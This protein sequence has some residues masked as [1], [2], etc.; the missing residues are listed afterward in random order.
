MSEIKRY[1]IN[2]LEED[3]YGQV[4]R[5]EDYQLLADKLKKLQKLN[6]LQQRKIEVLEECRDHYGY[7]FENVEILDS[8]TEIYAM[9]LDNDGKLARE[10]K[11]KCKEI[12]V[13][14]KELNHGI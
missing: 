4:V 8:T 10:T 5:Y 6:E 11:G 14:I 3:E 7:R 13:E 1:F 12:D 2:K 9:E